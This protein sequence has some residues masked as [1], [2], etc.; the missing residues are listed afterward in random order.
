MATCG[1]VMSIAS[2]QAVAAT[3]SRM[4]YSG[5]IRRAPMGELHLRHQ[6]RPGQLSGEVTSVGAQPDPPR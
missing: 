1:P 2:V 4:R 3:P 5:A 6:C